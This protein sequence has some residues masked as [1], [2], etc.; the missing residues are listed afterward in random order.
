MIGYVAPDLSLYFRVPIDVSV[1]RLLARRIKLKFYESGMDLGWSA[2]PVESFRM[3]QGK[4][5]EEYDRLVDELESLD[6]PESIKALQRN[7]IGR[8]EGAE[9]R[10]AVAGADPGTEVGDRG[11]NTIIVFTTRPD[12][13]YGA[14]YMVLA[15]ENPLV[16]RITAED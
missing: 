10:F 7:W 9:I 12:T 11:Y 16:D 13:L 14:T 2:N 8:S 6:W 15:P 5:L 1:D 3:F 4:V